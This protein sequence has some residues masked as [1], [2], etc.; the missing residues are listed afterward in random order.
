MG[1]RSGHKQKKT[2]GSWKDVFIAS[3]MC[4]LSVNNYATKAWKDSTCVYDSYQEYRAPDV[5][6]CYLRPFYPSQKYLLRPTSW[7]K[8]AEETSL[9][10]TCHCHITSSHTAPIQWDINKTDD[11]DFYLL[12]SL[13][14]TTLIPLLLYSQHHSAAL[15]HSLYPNF[16]VQH[17][18][19]IPTPYRTSSRARHTR[20]FT[21]L[22]PSYFPS[23]DGDT[24][25]PSLIHPS[26]SHASLLVHPRFPPSFSLHPHRTYI[27][28]R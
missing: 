24:A 8:G 14:H 11:D 17:H 4:I 5:N 25:T 26:S 27:T 18:R 23:T 2:R 28:Q 7:L 20:S 22:P 1:R 21:Q 13:F 19:P 3:E 12:V 16:Y 6:I 15:H 9:T 10:L